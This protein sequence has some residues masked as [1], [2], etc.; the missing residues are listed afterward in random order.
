MVFST[1][2]LTK[3]R[4]GEEKLPSR[5]SR[6]T[7]RHPQGRKN[8][9]L[10]PFYLV[11]FHKYSLISFRPFFPEEYKGLLVIYYLMDKIIIFRV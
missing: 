10:F 2:V 11:N 3:M 7:R 9:I 8:T 4:M 1:L 5:G 6:G